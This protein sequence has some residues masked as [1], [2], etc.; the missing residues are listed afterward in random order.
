MRVAYLFEPYSAVYASS[1]EP[2]PHQIAAV[3]ERMLAMKPLRFVL[4]DD[5]GAGKTIMTGLLIK[6]LI[7]RGD[8]QRCLIVCPSSLIEQ[9]QDELDRKFRLHFEILSGN[10]IESAHGSNIFLTAN[11]AVISI[12]T[13]A[14]REDFKKRLASSKWDMIVCDEA[15]KMSATVQGCEIKYTKRF[16]LGQL[17]GKIAK[18]FL[19]LTATPHNGKEEDFY[20]FMSLVAPER[21]NDVRQLKGRRVDVSDIMR[22]LM[23][24]DLL[25]FEG[26]PLFPE[27]ISHTVNYTLSPRESE[28]YRRVT[29]YVVDGFNRAERLNGT[30]RNSVG[31][32]MTILQR[33]LASSPMAIF[34]SL[35]R[36]T[37]R[38][39]QILREKTFLLD[40]N[41]GID[42]DFLDDYRD[43]SSGELD[44]KA[45]DIVEHVTAAKTI[46]E[47]RIE[48]QTLQCL[49]QTADIVLKSG[50]DRKW[51]ELSRL[52]Q[53]D[54]NILHRNGKR[55]KLIIFTEHR[56]T[57]NYLQQKIVALFGRADPV[58]VIHGGLNRKERRAVEE[59]FRQDKNPFIL[60]ATDAAGEGINLQTAHLMI[61]YDLPWNPNRLEQRFGRIHRIGQTNVCC[62]WNLVAAETREGQVMHRLLKKLD[63]ERAAL[64]GKVFDILGK[65][66]FDNKPLSE[67]LIDAIRYGNRPDVARRLE[68]LI[69]D[70][71]DT[72]KIKKLLREHALTHDTLNVKTVV[73]MEQSRERGDA[74]KLQPYFVEKFFVEAFRKLGGQIQPRGK[75]F[76]EINEVPPYVRRRSVEPIPKRYERVCC[77][78]THFDDDKPVELLT[79]GHPLMNVVINLTLEK[80]GD[81]L[82]RG[83][84]F[85]DDNDDG[86]DF[87]LMLLVETDSGR[88]KLVEMFEDGRE[89]STEQAPY[90]EYRKPDP[91]ELEI[92]LSALNKTDWITRE[93]ERREPLVIGAATVVPKGF[94]T[95]CDSVHQ[96]VDP[97]A[98]THIEKIAMDAVMKI[99]RELGN[100]PVDVS[101]DKRGY[102]VESVTPD[103][104]LRFIEV[105]GRRGDADTVTVTEN[106]ITTAL[107]ARDNFILALVIVNGD[108]A[109]VVYLKAPFTRPPDF[110]MVSANY[111]ISS[112]VKKGSLL[113]ERLMSV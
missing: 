13:V 88:L 77:S 96:S 41:D 15:H 35:E 111:K 44:R 9:W 54:E 22:R 64:G 62:L 90:F 8:V 63:N 87:R 80:F 24:E 21:F 39:Q 102:D 99:E 100:A 85:V 106:E 10:C 29:D 11:R 66:S 91:S 113:L 33:R 107:N 98:R 81:A 37:Q 83:T 84:I 19:L 46:E 86:K 17:L 108:K 18:N 109:R 5:P 2:L 56:D 4:A 55:E 65:I 3:Y 59:R 12:D 36:R 78:T 45:D 43:F 93:I 31:F 47:L 101:V 74:H 92:I 76:Y 94:L 38:L 1:I 70:C 27:R 14:R 104:R 23:K 103:N 61:N 79:I 51:R 34:K 53:D 6:E 97:D 95:A 42:E 60:V 112:L 72:C 89:H 71:L 40:Q 67:L 75:G 50:E 73:D 16:R 26:K 58:A 82:K 28:L 7:L 49:T 110:G 68:H 20:L 48:I 52:L 57:L 32:A 105:K 69:D 25:T 30:K